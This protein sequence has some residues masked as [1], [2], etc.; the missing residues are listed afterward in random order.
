MILLERFAMLPLTG[1]HSGDTDFSPAEKRYLGALADPSGS[2]AA[3][4]LAKRLIA[5]ALAELGGGPEPG[6]IEIL[7]AEGPGGGPPRVGLPAGFERPDLRL[8]LSLSHSATRVA[9]LLV[10]EGVE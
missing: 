3:R 2:R 8:H 6:R 10:I 7:P 1:A 9:A 4:L 5:N